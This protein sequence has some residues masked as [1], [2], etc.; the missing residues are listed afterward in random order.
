[1]KYLF[2][3]ASIML[4]MSCNSDRVLIKTGQKYD[5]VYYVRY[6][7]DR[8]HDDGELV[9]RIYYIKDGDTTHVHTHNRGRWQHPQYVFK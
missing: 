5:K 4:T 6:G 1:M 3:I 7:D 2:L 8:F 9:D